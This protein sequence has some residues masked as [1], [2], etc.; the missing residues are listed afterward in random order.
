MD[1]PSEASRLSSY[2][3][4]LAEASKPVVPSSALPAELRRACG[5]WVSVTAAVAKASFALTGVKAAGPVVD[6]V[7]A[8]SAVGDA[9]TELLKSIKSDTLLLRQEPLQTAVTLMGEAER[10]GPSDERWAQFLKQAVDSLYRAVSLAA[11]SDEKAIVYFG[12]GCAYLTLDKSGD[13]R[14]WIEKSVQS[15]R[16]ALDAF[17]GKFTSIVDTRRSKVKKIRPLDYAILMS[18]NT[19]IGMEFVRKRTARVEKRVE[20]FTHFLPFINSV[21]ICAATISGRSEAKVL[22][23]DP[24]SIDLSGKYLL[25]ET[26]FTLPVRKSPNT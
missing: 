3:R 11:S 17:L 13:A 9:Q 12:L 2:F 22:K 15:E 19:P 21:E 25:F 1:Q 26:T 14:H 10:V 6:L 23:M 20:S 5:P 18:T 4:E 24:L 8:L 16:E 7:V